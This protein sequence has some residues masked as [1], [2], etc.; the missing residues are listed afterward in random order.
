MHGSDYQC[1]CV[2]DY[3]TTDCMDYWGHKYVF[4]ELSEDC[5]SDRWETGYFPVWP[6]AVVSALSYGLRY[7]SKLEYEQF[8]GYSLLFNL[9]LMYCYGFL[10]GPSYSIS[11]LRKF[12][13]YGSQMEK[14]FIWMQGICRTWSFRFSS[15]RVHL[16][17]RSCT[18][19]FGQNEVHSTYPKNSYN[20]ANY[21]PRTTN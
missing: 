21:R 20:G 8:P 13:V 6:K 14:C 5:A 15:L 7:L 18:T 9:N 10:F 16:Q 12:T 1:V 4:V 19:V 2:N 17:Q 3:N 11:L